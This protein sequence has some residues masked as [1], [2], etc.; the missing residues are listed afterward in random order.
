MNATQVAFRFPVLGFTRDGCWGFRDLDRLTLCNTLAWKNG[1]L[2]GMDLV[3]AELRC[4][5]VRSAR[6]L[7][8]A[9]SVRAWLVVLLAGP[10]PWRVDYELEAS[11]ATTLDAV[12]DR[13]CGHIQADPEGGSTTAR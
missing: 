11:P 7:G 5:T 13:V 2:V 6:R 8:R 4:W 3:D 10:P 1:S 12:K 9:W